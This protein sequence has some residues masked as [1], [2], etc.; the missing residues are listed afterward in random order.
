MSR[1]GKL[2]IKLPPGTQARIENNFIYVKGPKGELKEKLHNIVNVVIENEEII[3]K[4]KNLKNKKER[5][6]WGLYR[7]LINNMVIG[8]NQGFEKKLQINGI[9]YKVNLVGRV[10]VLNLGF[11]HPVNF[12]LPDG[13]D[14]EI[15]GNVVT[16][17]GSDRQ[18]VGEVSAQIR[19]IR[20][21][22]PYKGKGIKYLDEVLIKKE[23]KTAAKAE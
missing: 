7:S 3:V 4:I 16:I 8:I 23:G 5:A 15:E 12:K 6:F 9:G 17:K 19:K 11:S 10:L 1:I 22:E 21:P 14:A 20:K 18:L 2:P 13:I